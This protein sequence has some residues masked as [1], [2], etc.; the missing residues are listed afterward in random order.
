MLMGLATAI[1]SLTTIRNR[2][3]LVHP[4]ENRLS[5]P[6]ATLA[7][8]AARTLLHYLDQKMVYD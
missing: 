2:G 4:N 3:S 7:V 6:E 1:D 5:E 8:N